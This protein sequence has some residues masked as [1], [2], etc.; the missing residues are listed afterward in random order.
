MRLK[1]TSVVCLELWL[2]NFW[3]FIFSLTETETQNFSSILKKWT[4]TEFQTRLLKT[5]QCFSDG[6]YFSCWLSK[7]LHCFLAGRH[8]G[9]TFTQVHRTQWTVQ[10]VLTAAAG[11]PV[12]RTI[13]WAAPWSCCRT[14]PCAGRTEQHGLGDKQWPL[15][16]YPIKVN[17]GEISIYMF[18]LLLWAAAGVWWSMPG[19]VLHTSCSSTINSVTLK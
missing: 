4:G 19:L 9:D 16:V 2:I 5:T 8:T 1:N 7:A 3:L 15:T 13:P 17:L 11:K 12:R 14:E 10:A 6:S 18:K